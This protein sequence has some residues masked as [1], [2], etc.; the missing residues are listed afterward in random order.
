MAMARFFRGATT[1]LVLQE[2]S[3]MIIFFSGCL[4]HFFFDILHTY[5]KAFGGAPGFV[6]LGFVVSS[7]MA[8]SLLRT[9]KCSC[10]ETGGHCT[11]NIYT[12]VN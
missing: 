12:R 9:S 4:P 1:V 8:T 10:E 11:A 5:V 7:E 6:P 3:S 2:S